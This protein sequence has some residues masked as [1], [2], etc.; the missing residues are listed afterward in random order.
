MPTRTSRNDV[1]GRPQQN[2]N[3][4]P[5]NGQVPRRSE[6]PTDDGV[7]QETKDAYEK[8]VR[9]YPNIGRLLAR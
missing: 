9:K 5:K 2:Q 4:L 1:Q 6:V 7:S 8:S 3:G